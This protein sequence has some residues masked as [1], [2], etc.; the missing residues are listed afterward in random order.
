MIGFFVFQNVPNRH[1]C[2]F[3]FSKPILHT[4]S[5]NIILKGESDVKKRFVK[6][7]SLLLCVLI[8][9]GTVTISKRP[10]AEAAT[11]EYTAT[12]TSV[13]EAPEGQEQTNI[14]HMDRTVTENTSGGF[15]VTL[16]SYIDDMMASSTPLDVLFVLDASSSMYSLDGSKGDKVVNAVDHIISVLN[17]S[18][19]GH[20]V[21]CITFNTDIIDS[22]TTSNWVSAETGLNHYLNKYKSSLHAV[23]SYTYTDKAMEEAK[24]FLSKNKDDTHQQ[25]VVLV[26]DGVPAS[27]ITMSQF[28]TI[29]AND[30]LEAA[31]EIKATGAIISVLQFDYDSILIN[32]D[33]MKKFCERLSSDYGTNA[34]SM[35]ATCNNVYPE[36]TYNKYA[37][38]FKGLAK[39]FKKL[40]TN[41]KLYPFVLNSTA[42]TQDIV[43]PYFT[44]SNASCKIQKANY[45]SS[46]KLTSWS[47][48]GSLS[49]NISGQ[50]VYVTGFDYIAGAVSPYNDQSARLVITYHIDPI[51]DFFGGN[52]IPTVTEG[53]TSNGNYTSGGSGLYCNGVFLKPFMNIPVNVE[54]REPTVTTGEDKWLDYNHEVDWDE[55]YTVPDLENNLFD[56]TKNEFVKA[57]VTTSLNSSNKTI[58]QATGSTVNVA[59]IY[60]KAYDV[61]NITSESGDKLSVTY[62]IEPTNAFNKNDSVGRSASRLSVTKSRTLKAIWEYEVEFEL[63]PLWPDDVRTPPESIYCGT[64]IDGG[65]AEAR[66][67][68]GYM[69]GDTDETENY[70]FSGF[71]LKDISRSD[72]IAI[73]IY[74]GFWY[75]DPNAATDICVY[76]QSE[77]PPFDGDEIEYDLIKELTVQ[78]KP[79]DVTISKIAECDGEDYR[80]I[81][82]CYNDYIENVFTEYFPESDDWISYYNDSGLFQYVLNDGSKTKL[83]ALASVYL[84][85]S[86]GQMIPLWELDNGKVCC[87]NEDCDDY[88]VTKSLNEMLHYADYEFERIERYNDYREIDIYFNRVNHT[89]SATVNYDDNPDAQKTYSYSGLPTGCEWWDANGNSIVMFN[90]YV[91]YR[92]GVEEIGYT[93]DGDYTEYTPFYSASYAE[94]PVLYDHD[95]YS[96][97]DCTLLDDFLYTP[98][99]V[100]GWYIPAYD[101]NVTVELTR[102]KYDLT[103]TKQ[104]DSTVSQKDIQNCIF[105]LYE[106][107]E[108]DGKRNYNLICRFAVGVDEFEYKNGILTASKTIKNL[109]AGN[110]YVLE[111]E[112]WSYKTKSDWY[113]GTEN[114]TVVYGVS[115]TTI[116]KICRNYNDSNWTHAPTVEKGV[117][118]QLSS[119]KTSVVATNIKKNVKAGQG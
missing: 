110:E 56:G 52:S 62:T 35:N 88:G 53:K 48:D 46:K 115:G 8:A 19:S 102:M 11:N 71:S 15:D 75:D 111:E 98:D 31:A 25:A 90:E 72:G 4:F 16:T 77:T 17:D 32:D 36:K 66:S 29:V 95:C 59:S 99:W 22:A 97:E 61:Y 50:S 83:M 18:G 86:C 2:S 3:P 76:L 6:V 39:E 119:D 45:N 60:G 41:T 47:D 74:S 63:D 51:T 91:D 38:D 112:T 101:I 100:Y 44:I 26:T 105:G 81:D 89:F 27:L 69:E 23:F 92:E 49:A 116:E 34:T 118:N 43:T 87:Y 108:I 12:L 1:I 20:R 10:E 58:F 21:A 14:L 79:E 94:F 67:Y 106:V 78:M 54:L 85:P 5:E 107:N 82:S 28:S 7:L 104:W 42:V 109:C 113:R 114:E 40:I 117:R 55:Y 13:S 80:F 30:A 96:I 103:V 64:S 57:T 33:N 73:Y 93:E 9:V 84:C 24:S 37:E 70:I 65:E 68:S